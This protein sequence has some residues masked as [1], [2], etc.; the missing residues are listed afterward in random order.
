MFERTSHAVCEYV[1]SMCGGRLGE[2][3]AMGGGYIPTMCGCVRVSA[4]EPQHWWIVALYDVSKK[5]F[6]GPAR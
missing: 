2:I 6:K 1:V 5:G 4:L 3:L